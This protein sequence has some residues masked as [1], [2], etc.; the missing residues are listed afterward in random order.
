MGVLTG[1]KEEKLV[2]AVEPISFSGAPFS[3]ADDVAWVNEL[4]LIVVDA[5]KRLAEYDDDNESTGRS[6]RVKSHHPPLLLM[7]V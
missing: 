2:H 7:T 3:Q 5:G 4:I 6:T 1:V